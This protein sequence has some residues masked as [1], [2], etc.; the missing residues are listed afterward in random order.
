MFNNHPRSGANL[1]RGR[2]ALG[3]VCLSAG[4]VIGVVTAAWAAG[5]APPTFSASKL[6]AGFQLQTSYYSVAEEVRNDGFMNHYRVTVNGKTY[7]ISGTALM[8]ERLREL[9]VLPAMEAVERTDVY[10][11]AVLAAAEGPLR[12]AKGLV[13]APINTVVG[14]VS[15]VGTMFSNLG[16][17]LFGGGSNQE[18]GVFKTALGYDEAKRRFAYKFGID[19][20]TS[21]EPVS[22][23]LSEIS[24]AGV[25]GS[26]TVSAAFQGIPTPAKGAVTVTKT[27][28]AMNQ[29]VRNSSPAELKEIN[30]RI[31]R[32]MKVNKNVAELF[33]E[34]PNFS[35][36]QKTHLVNALATIGAHDRHYFINRAILVQS[37]EM[38]FFMR[39][40]AEMIAAYHLKV[41]PVYRFVRLGRMPAVQHE[42]G[43]LVMIIPIDHLAWTD[44]IAQQYADNVMGTGSVSGITGGQ[45][46]IAGS[47]SQPARA[48]LEDHGWKVFENTAEQL[49][50]D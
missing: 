8:K 47:I 5:E 24:W 19:P 36:T 34:H 40:W 43:L 31:L 3:A 38:A 49:R 11:K 23:R 37:E 22:E 7:A 15:G 4:L 26:L 29:L 35:P 18:S 44:A 42:D 28:N 14:V 41:K 20:Y 10:K 32:G 1:L 39:R 48:L 46:W 13:T 25:A 30:E 16:H 17:S 12:T 9:S 50:L 33:L 6:L 27:A 45:V 2:A 21:F